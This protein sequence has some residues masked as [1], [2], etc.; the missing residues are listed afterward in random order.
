MSNENTH[1]H[2][3]AAMDTH[4]HA[5][6]NVCMHSVH[7]SICWIVQ[8]ALPHKASIWGLAIVSNKLVWNLSQRKY[9]GMCFTSITE[10]RTLFPGQQL[11]LGKADS[12]SIWENT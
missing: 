10:H 4:A 3:H 1:S 11:T 9:Y 7:V 8:H 5:H 12:K 2:M 6:M